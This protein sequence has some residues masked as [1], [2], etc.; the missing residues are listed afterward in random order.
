MGVAR[1]CTCTVIIYYLFRYSTVLRSV[2][3]QYGNVRVQVPVLHLFYVLYISCT[4]TCA[5]FILSAGLYGTA[6][7]RYGMGIFGLKNHI[8]RLPK[9]FWAPKK[10]YVSGP[11]AKT[12]PSF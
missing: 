11:R 12:A 2:R 9:L 5:V 3:V 8:W 7:I 10:L 6:L 1:Y 4:C